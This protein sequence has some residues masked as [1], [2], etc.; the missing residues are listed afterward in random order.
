MNQRYFYYMLACPACRGNLEQ[1][2]GIDDHELYCTSCKFIFPIIDDIPILFRCNVKDEMESL[3]NRYWNSEENVFLNDKLSDVGNSIF[4]DYNYKSEINSIVS[5]YEADNLDLILDVGC[6]N[7]RCME[8]FPSNSVKVGIDT[9]LNFLKIAQKKKRGDFLVCGELWHLPFKDKIFGTILSC[10]VLQQLQYQEEAI[11]E[12][13]RVTRVG[14]SVI[15]ELYNTWNLKTLSPFAPRGLK[16]NNWFQ[17]KKWMHRSN[18]Y[19]FQGRGVGFGSHKYLLNPF[20]IN[21]FL[22]NKAQGLLKGYYN[23]IYRL[24]RLIGGVIPFR[25]MMEK[26]VIKATAHSHVKSKSLV[27]K[28][29]NKFEYLYKSSDFYNSI[30]VKERRREVQKIDELVKDNRFHLLAAVEWIKRAQEAT[31]DRGVSRG[32]SVGWTDYLN[33]RGWQPSY[34]ETTGYIIP[35]FLEC[36][37]YFNDN[38]L[39]E[40]AFEMAEWEIDIQ[41]ENGAVMGGTINTKP[42]PAVFNTGQVMLGWL[43][44][45][46]KY[47]DKKYLNAS[48]KAAHYLLN[49]Q[50]KDGS[51]RIGNS[52][53]ARSMYTTYNSRVGWALIIHG[54]VTGNRTYV[55]S[56]IK[57]IQHTLSQQKENGWFENNCLS[58]PSAPLLHTICYAV[59]GLMGAYEVL[60]IDEYLK[61][62]I[63]AVNPLMEQIRDDG[64][65]PGRFNANWSGTVKWSCLTGTAQLAAV[66]LR[67][68]MI[69]QETQYLSKAR[70][71]LSFLKKTQN[72]VTDNNGLRGGIKGSYPFDGSYGRYEVLNWATKFYIDAL[73]L[74]E[75]VS[76]LKI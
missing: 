57:N 24:E 58:D 31:D 64:S 23:A 72:C 49:T 56:G 43:D 65:M 28:V 6:K 48:E 60:S 9:S 61:S 73:L 19:G 41:M 50:A 71:M 42:T 2:N 11:R 16:Y 15:L 12:M 1:R 39:K 25:Y 7:G 66:M 8:T 21:A 29:V 76:Q 47:K 34:P 13:S 10:K 27:K 70:I 26:F 18:L 74:E 53:F 35:T 37:E 33:I 36:A 3:S 20:N 45:F 46:I 63:L 44:V 69:T 32:Y 59:E 54:N 62:A 40:R 17:V 22:S 30:A 51:W 4:S 67:L 38:D 55:D 75:K 68:Y 14:G 5:Y 52:Q